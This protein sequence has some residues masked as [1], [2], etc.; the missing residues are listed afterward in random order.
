MI[1]LM[2]AAGNSKIFTG[3]FVWMG[4]MQRE[5]PALRLRISESGADRV[6]R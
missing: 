4:A 5:R 2:I 3:A 6:P 1:Y